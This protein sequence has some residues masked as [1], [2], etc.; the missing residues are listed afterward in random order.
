MLL[1]SCSGVL[2][3]VKAECAAWSL[4]VPVTAV[5]SAFVAAVLVQTLIPLVWTV[6]CYL[7][8]PGKAPV[9]LSTSK[10]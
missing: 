3:Q 6:L 8:F 4:P 1:C 10:G 7:C 9:A 5:F 2:L